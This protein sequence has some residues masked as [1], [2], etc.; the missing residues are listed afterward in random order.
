MRPKADN[1]LFLPY[2]AYA[3]SIKE[4]IRQEF[5]RL[6]LAPFD[7]LNVV[8]TKR[9][10]ERVFHEV[11]RLNRR[12]WAALC[13][14]VYEWV[15]VQYGNDPPDRDWTKV[16]DDWLKGY[17]PVTRYRHDTETER[18]RLRLAEGI[19]TARE[20][21]DRKMLD[22]VV[23]TAAGLLLAQSLQ[24]GL[25]IMGEMQTEAHRE[26]AEDATEGLLYHA[27][28][29]ERTCEVCAAD[30]GKVFMVKDAPRIPRHYRC[31]CWYTRAKGSQQPKG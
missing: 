14:W 6:T 4:K 3:K 31:R 21:G 25:D 26:A 20:Q 2:D 27:C 13:E 1:S 5:R 29:D 16:V 30:D 7:Q 11:D 8:G 24:A 15:Y 19:L 10:T 23:K 17:D 12:H 18:K 28:H 9:L 22:E